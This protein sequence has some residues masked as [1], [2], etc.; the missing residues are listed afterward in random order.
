M[1]MSISSRLANPVIVTLLVKVSDVPWI[2]TSKTSNQSRETGREIC[3]KM[4]S[5][6]KTKKKIQGPARESIR[7]RTGGQNGQGLQ[8]G[9]GLSGL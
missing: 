7:G 5:M 9:R 4:K 2:T 3:N 1:S 6:K 8:G